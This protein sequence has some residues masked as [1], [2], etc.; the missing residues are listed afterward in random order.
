MARLGASANDIPAPSKSPAPAPRKVP[1]GSVRY[2][3]TSRQTALDWSSGA[4]SPTYRFPRFFL[5][6]DPRD[7][8]DLVF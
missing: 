2:V 6:T 8:I 3:N 5:P 4:F 1:V 7:P